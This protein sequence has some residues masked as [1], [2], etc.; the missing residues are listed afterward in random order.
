MLGRD[1]DLNAPGLSR[2]AADEPSV[3]EL[4]DHPVD[5][6]RRNLEVALQVGLGGRTAVDLGVGVDERQV[7]A[8]QLR[9]LGGDRHALPRMIPFRAGGTDEHTLRGDAE[10]RG[11]ERT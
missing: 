9:E 4:D 1:Q 11:A 6:R 8:L 10:R 2:L 5:A 7:L 3:L